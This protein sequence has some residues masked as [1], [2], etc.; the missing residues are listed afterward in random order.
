MIFIMGKI[1]RKRVW[2]GTKPTPEQI[3]E[4]RAAARRPIVFDEDCPELTDEELAEFAVLA[5]ERDA[6]RKKEILSLRVSSD[7]VRIGKSFGK[8]W[9]GIMARLLDLAIKDP[10]LLKKAL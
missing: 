4:I 9:T 10:A 3:R 6:R 1:I 7:T 5:K 8:G 2:V